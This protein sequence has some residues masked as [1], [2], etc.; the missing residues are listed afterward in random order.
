MTLV[1][2]KQFHAIEAGSSACYQALVRC[3]IVP[4]IRS[5][6]L[7]TGLWAISF[8]QHFFPAP[9]ATLGLASGAL[10]V[11]SV[12]ASLDFTLTLGTVVAQ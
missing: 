10:T 3:S 6:S 2:L 1:A 5:A 4:N 9:S 11:A 12:K 7:E 8:P